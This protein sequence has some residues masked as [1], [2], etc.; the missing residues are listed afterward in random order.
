MKDKDQS[1]N[2]L[3]EAI[4]SGNASKNQKTNIR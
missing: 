1:T 4:F 2:F 3:R